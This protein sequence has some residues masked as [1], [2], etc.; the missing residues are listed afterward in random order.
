[1][2]NGSKPF[3]R[4]KTFNKGNLVVRVDLAM[5]NLETSLMEDSELTKEKDSNDDSMGSATTVANMATR[6]RRVDPSG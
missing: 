2:N 5:A 3:N 1:M 4:N 6:Q